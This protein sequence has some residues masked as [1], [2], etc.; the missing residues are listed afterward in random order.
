MTAA[1]PQGTQPVV[2]VG[3]GM[4]G[5]TVARE[6]RKLDS[7]VPIVMISRDD[8]SFYSKPMLSNALAMKKEP[9]MLPVSM[10]WQWRRNWARGFASVR[11]SSASFR[12]GT[13]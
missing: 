7:T 3:T 2:I 8:G 9:H 11:K 4:A 5:Y 1:Q 13:R 6:L 12:P 10:P